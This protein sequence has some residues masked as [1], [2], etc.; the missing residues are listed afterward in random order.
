MWSRSQL[1]EKAKNALNGNYWRVVLVTLIVFMIGGAISSVD[2]NSDSEDIETAFE[3]GFTAGLEGDDFDYED[4]YLFD[5]EIYDEEDDEAGMD[6]AFGIIVIV[7]VFILVIV[8]ITSMFLSIF[9]FAP[10]EVGTKRF[11][12]KNLNQP[13]EVKEVAFGF[14]NN[15]KNIVKILF[16][17]DLYLLGWSLLFVIP[18]IVK[19]YEYLMV[20][21]LLAENPNLTKDQAFALSKQMMTGHKWNAFVLDLSFIGWDLLSSFTLGILSIFYVEPYRNLTFAALYE[22]ISLINGRPAFAAQQPNAGTPV[23]PMEMN[24]FAQSTVPVEETPENNNSQE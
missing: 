7:V 14:D 10:L 9:I 2:I 6:F 12:F 8:A 19:S 1:K 5:D 4:E 15:Y 13:A 11:F 20:P 24:P 23:Q 21:Y 22:E 17:R 3:E 16:F 18:G